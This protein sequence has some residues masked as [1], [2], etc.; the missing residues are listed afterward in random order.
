MAENFGYHV[1]ADGTVVETGDA[2]GCSREEG[3]VEYARKGGVSAAYDE[4]G[5][6]SDWRCCYRF[7]VFR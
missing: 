1:D 3:I 6:H 4:D 5:W 7:S 2:D